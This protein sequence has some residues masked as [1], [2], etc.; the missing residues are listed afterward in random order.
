MRRGEVPS[1][2]DL[3]EAIRFGRLQDVDF[4][5]DKHFNQCASWIRGKVHDGAPAR[6]P[7][8]RSYETSQ[9]IESCVVADSPEKHSGEHTF[10][11]LYEHLF[12]QASASLRGHH[13]QWR[14]PF[15][16]CLRTPH[17]IERGFSI[18][19]RG[20]CE[21]QNARAADGSIRLFF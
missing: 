4:E 6:M 10:I 3:H 20:L 9:T 14:L 15:K 21:S 11:N 19:K 5:M 1:C 12:Y 2:I 13:L 8:R 18:S 17:P 16:A 7:A